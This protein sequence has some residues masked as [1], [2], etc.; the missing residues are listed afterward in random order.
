MES[1]DFRSWSP[2][3]LVLA[4]DMGDPEGTEIYSMPAFEYHGLYVGMVQMYYGL[5]DQGD[6]EIQLAASRDGIRFQ[7]LEDR[8]P[9]LPEGPVGSWD[10]FNIALGCLP[11]VLVEDEWWFYYSGRTYRHSP[12]AGP[13]TGP[14]RGRTGLA[15]CRRGRVAVLESSFD[16]GI[17]ETVPLHDTG[18][19]LFLNADARWGSIQVSVLDADGSS[20]SAGTATVEGV[21]GTDIPV[22]IPTLPDESPAP[23]RLRFELRNAGIHEFRWEHS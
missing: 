21:D 19:R 12:Y 17:L 2:P 20:R 10:R 4:A 13:D 1:R 7:R 23:V 15:T 16:G 8:T 9:F 18:S 14:H 11:P 6:L 22:L 3:E 5:P